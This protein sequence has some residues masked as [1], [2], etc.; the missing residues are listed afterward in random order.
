MARLFW[1]LLA[2]S[3]V[4]VAF[5]SSDDGDKEETNDDENDAEGE[6]DP[7]QV[8]DVYVLTDDNFDKFVDSQDIILVEFYAPWCGHCKQLAPEYAKAAKMLK[9]TAVAVPLAKVD[10]TTNEELAKRF[11][12][13]GYPTMKYKKDGQWI[14]FDGPRD[15]QGIV[16]YMNEKSDPNYKPPPEAVVTVTKDNFDDFINSADLVLVEFYAPW[17]G[18]CKKLAPEYEKAAKQL[19]DHDP[20]V[21]LAKVDATV[22]TELAKDFGVS[23]Y[24]TL[25]MFRKGK[26]QEYKGPRDASGIA[27]YMHKQ[28]GEAAKLL[29]T[30]KEVKR[31][32]SKDMAI[33][34]GF[35][36]NL[37]DPTLRTYMDVANDKR[38]DLNFGYTLLPEARDLY[39]V[40]VGQVVVFTPE[41]FYTKFEPKWHIL[42]AKDKSQ[43]DI[44]KFIEQKMLPL[45]GHYNR[46]S[47]QFYSDH[48]FL[49]LA[50]YTVDWSFDH[51]DATQFWRHKIADVAKDF[52]DIKFAIADDQEYSASTMKDFGLDESGEELNIGCFK[53]GK[54]YSMEPMEEYDDDEVREFLKKLQ[55]GKI[56]PHIKSQPVP[57]RKEGP[58]KVVVGKTFEDVVFDKTKDVFIEMYAPWC[59]HCKNLEPIYKNLAKDL[60]HDKNL[61]IAK[62]DA[63]A[64]D[65]PE[66]YSVSGFPTIYFAPADK[67]AEP[68]KFEG[69]RTLEEMKKY[70]EENAVVSFGKSAKAKEEL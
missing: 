5:V 41:K 59:G 69:G 7:R 12:I 25:K 65:L 8:D 61:V 49:C 22:E 51:R 44:A 37:Q 28:S 35:F 47:E 42:D 3:L 46:G 1:V 56:S 38:E 16:D 6:G 2:L 62:I 29:P 13:E 4:S 24:P 19:K 33:I 34:I 48:K 18:H 23:G 30:M 53:D 68:L 63:T 60:K 66:N 40:N 50:F 17:C 54:K 43:K 14:D 10:A 11:S 26:D 70:L 57:K 32:D 20:P 39:K 27:D 9:E 45:V 52:K 64:N 36:D 67:K 15:A 31:R 21:P 58:V 55:K